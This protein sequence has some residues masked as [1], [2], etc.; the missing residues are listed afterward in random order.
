MNN[1]DYSHPIFNG[2]EISTI[3]KLKDMAKLVSKWICESLFPGT[4]SDYQ[5]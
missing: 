1:M 2:A 5:F 3:F 4:P